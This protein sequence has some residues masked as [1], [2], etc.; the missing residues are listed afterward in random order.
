MALT[1]S[2]IH[3]STDAGAL[4]DITTDFLCFVTE[5]FEVIS[6]SV[7]YIYQSALLFAP[8]SSLVRKLYEWYISPIEPRVMTDIPA[9]WN[10]STASARAT[11]EVTHAVWSSHGQ[12]VAVGW[13][14]RVELRDSNS[15]RSVSILKP[16]G[17]PHVMVAPQS[18]AFSPDGRLL[19]C[20]YHR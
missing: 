18:L 14:D 1:Q 4:L 5:F 16:P 15:L 20:A 6:R 8:R 19:A 10:S 13:A 17:G 7:P 2:Q 11:S 9:S 3:A 12:L